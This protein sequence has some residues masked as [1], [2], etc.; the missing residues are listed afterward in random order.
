MG[1][2]ASG[3]DEKL[4]SLE[5]RIAALEKA[6][7]PSAVATTSP[8]NAP[9]APSAANLPTDARIAILEQEMARSLKTV[10]VPL[11]LNRSGNEVCAERGHI[12]LSVVDNAGSARYDLNNKFCGHMVADCNARVTKRQHCGAG[13]DYVF[14]PVRFY[15][16]P[17]AKAQCDSVG[18]ETCT[19]SP[20]D[21][22]AICLE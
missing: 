21:L 9:S 15:R 22:T 7:P 12:C 1:C 5:Q 16:S 6:Q 19:A 3:D 8:S 20:E 2:G 17:G 10:R 13:Y 18:T 11:A 4:T 14:A